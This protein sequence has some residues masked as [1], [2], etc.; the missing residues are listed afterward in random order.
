MMSRSALARMTMDGLGW[1]AG[2]TKPPEI[3]RAFADGVGLSPHTI[4]RMMNERGMH[5][6]RGQ[7]QVRRFTVVK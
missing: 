3:C 4:R 1:K 2:D 5:I 6:V 7:H